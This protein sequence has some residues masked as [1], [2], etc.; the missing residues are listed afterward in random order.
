M[1]PKHHHQEQDNITTE[2]KSCCHHHQHP[3]PAPQ[4]PTQSKGPTIY[5]CP[6]HAE[7]RQ[8]NPGTCPICGMALEPETVSAAEEHNPEYEAMNRRFWIALVLS[9]PVFILAMSEHVLNQWLPTHLSIWIQMILATPI[10]AGCGWPF[11]Q[12]GWQSL[13]TGHLNMFTL[14]AIGTGVAWGYSVIATLFPGIFPSSFRNEEG[15]VAV[16][17]EAAAVITTL[18]LLG[19][20]LELKARAQTGGAIRA[21]LQLS[22]TTAHR[23][24]ENEQ[25][26]EIDLGHIQAGDLLRVRPGEKIPV[27]GEIVNGKSYIDESMI[28]GEAMPVA[29]A[30]GSRVIGATLN[31]T[32]SFT[33]KATHVGHDT[34]LARIVQMVSDAQRSR[35]P[36]QR[37]ADAV[38]GW[39]VPLVIFIAIIAAICWAMWGPQPAFSYALIAAVSVLIIACPCALGLA[40]PMSIMVGIGKGASQG[41]LIKNAEALEQMEKVDTLIVDKTGTLTE[42]RPKLTQI[43][44]LPDWSKDELLA[45]AAALENNSEHPLG[46]AIVSAAKEKNLSFSPVTDFEAVIG[47]GVRGLVNGRPIAIGN[48]KL[49]PASE[50]TNQSLFDQAEALRSEGASVMFMAVEHQIAAI[51]AVTDPIKSTTPA[52]I[53]TL[54]QEGIEVVMLTGDSQKTAEAVAAK[55]GITQVVAEIMPEDKGRIV[56]QWQQKNRVVAM[57]GD[58]VNDAPALAKADIGIAMG[59]GTDVAIES[60]GVT[61]LYGDLQGIVK[62]RLLSKATM[63][64]I[65]QNLFFAFIYNALGVPVAAGILYPVMGLL[66]NPM[67]AAAAM[68]LSS[69]SVII[70]ALR[71]R[72]ETL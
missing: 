39:F 25:E 62:A 36:I 31:Q 33:M 28:T 44:T 42:G 18:V 67:I 6:M 4:Q 8:E 21:L 10:V 51:L 34:M 40:T 12:R 72:W 22:P 3:S 37:L 48:L 32:G 45:L 27:D 59:T 38:A 53:S 71:L 17:F 63:R 20:V 60:A 49:M 55:L 64:N 35:A 7:I 26:T 15:L 56:A 61:L 29:K 70:N 57:A 65:R 43:V 16:Y 58:G 11:F 47:K 69:V 13:Q 19:Q 54:Q 68:S 2:Q 9:L 41:V 52:A 24:D 66:L 14:I 30:K 50:N 23:L 5:T 46:Y 1:N